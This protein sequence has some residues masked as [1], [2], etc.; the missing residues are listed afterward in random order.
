MN[1][2]LKKNIETELNM[3][4][5]ISAYSNRLAH[6]NLEEKKLLMGAISS[7]R[8]SI[9]IINSAIP[10][11]LKEIHAQQPLPKLENKLPPLPK[12]ENVRIKGEQYDVEVVLHKKD[13]ERL[14]KEL[15]ISESFIKRIKKKKK[16]Q[17]EVYFEFQAARGYLKLANKYFLGL[18]DKFVNQGKFKWLYYSLK[19]ANIDILFESYIAMIFFTTSLSIIG[20]V[21]IFAFLMFFNIGITFPFI[22]IYDGSYLSRFVRV[23][24]VVFA[25]PVLTYFIVYFY[26]STER[27]TLETKVNQELPFAV[28][29]MSAVSGSGIAPTGIF[30][31]IGMNK[32]YPYLRKEIRKV[33]N[34]IN[35]Y[36]YD[37]VTALNN[38]AKTVPSTKLSDLFSGLSTTIT[39]GA[40][41]Q[42]FFTKRAE[43]LLLEYRLERENYT[44]LIETF[45]DIYISIVI[46][47]PMVFL[48]LMIMISIS[49]I[50]VGFSTPQLTFISIFG[51]AIL[52]MLFLFFLQIKQPPY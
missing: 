48:L 6:A 43:T 27:S 32:E 9:K 37:L 45:L 29:H 31:I 28:I 15:S 7:L 20:G 39:A 2:S 16:G 14:F 26:P 42:S 41:L 21:F 22:S 52:N 46:A 30:K 17:D 40:N 4:R 24:W 10:E 33:L 47:A 18:A 13:K 5:E 3:L 23:F 12:L 34:Q 51:I 8:K 1:E 11:M 50:S 36:G 38:A 35:L 25:V 44:K 19:R 49:G